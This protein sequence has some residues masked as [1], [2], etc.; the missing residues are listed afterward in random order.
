TG[1]DGKWSDLFIEHDIHIRPFRPMNCGFEVPWSDHFKSK[2]DRSHLKNIA[3]RFEQKVIRGELMLTPYG[4][5]GTPVYS[6]SREMR[7]QILEKGE[8]TIFLDLKPDLSEED[9]KNRLEQKRTKDSVSNILRK[10]LKLD[11]TAITLLKECTSQEEFSNHLAKKM[12][13]LP[14]RLHSPRP[15]EES[16]ST[17]GGVAMDEINESFALKKLPH[18]YAIGEMLDWDTITGGYL[19]QM[20]FSQ[21]YRVYKSISHE[22]SMTRNT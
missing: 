20:C 19:L 10:K 4:L 18:H 12:K 22:N 16:I 3:A 6:L 14:L 1:S 13:N 11:T 8:A 9:I 2:I 21:A 5:E 17:S 15:L 7:D